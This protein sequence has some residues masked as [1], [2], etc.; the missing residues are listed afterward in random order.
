VPA[1]VS[2]VRAKP[3]HPWVIGGIDYGPAIAT[4][5]ELSAWAFDL[6]ARDVA[7]WPSGQR[8]VQTA[9]RF[10][11]D[12]LRGT[13]R[14]AAPFEALLFTAELLARI[15]E[16]DLHLGM[17]EMVTILDRLGLPTELV[18]LMPRRQANASAPM[19]PPIAPITPLRPR[20]AAVV[21]APHDGEPGQLCPQFRNAA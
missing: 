16:A 14:R 11:L 18:P 8:R 2:V 3:I 21:A 12:R 19:H 15:F 9:H 7:D 5:R 4:V 13:Y 6:A 1:A 10:V 20:P 17:S